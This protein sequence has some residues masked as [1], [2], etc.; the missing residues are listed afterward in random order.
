M[1]LPVYAGPSLDGHPRT[2]E[3]V[4][5]RQ[6]LGKY[7][8]AVLFRDGLR[9]VGWTRPFKSALDIGSGP[10]LQPRL[11]RL[12]GCVERLEAL[13]I[14]DGS[15][16]CPDPLL[17]RH[18]RR[19][20]WLYPFYRL[21]KLAPAAVRQH[22]GL[23][24]KIDEKLP[25]GIEDFGYYPDES[26]YGSRWRRGRTL[27]AYHVGDVF[28]HRGRYDLVTSFMA[29]EYFRFGEVA[30]KVAELLDPGGI[31]G[32]LV[33]Y[34]WYPVN[35][36]LLYGRFPYLLQQLAS[37]EVKGYY[38]TVHPELPR[39]GLT[40]RMGYCDAGRPTVAD[41][42]LAAYRHG[43]DPLWT[44]RLHPDHYSNPRAVLGPLAIDALP[45]W[46]LEA[47]LQNARRWKPGLT[48]TDL[49]TSH[50]MMIFRKR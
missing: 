4:G 9:R 49:M 48:L 37:D 24:R 15:R 32:F 11:L 8:E 39:E 6:F 14:Y 1:H 44:L 23:C 41:Y 26:L 5:F 25:I 13:D 22:I 12:F 18:A 21:Q 17:R 19:L 45:G 38:E 35:S 34:W 10:A 7:Y 30:A 29:L 42:E 28:A 36:T 3:K 20:R 2:S 16:R 46:S 27:G 31:F 33:S 40:R 50:V 43:F 47:V